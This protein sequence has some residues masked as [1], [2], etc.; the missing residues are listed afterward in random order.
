VTLPQ[1]TKDPR[2]SLAILEA[3]NARPPLG[4]RLGFKDG[5][6]PDI[7]L[8]QKAAR[9]VLLFLVICAVALADL[10]EAAF[11]RAAVILIADV[12][13]AALNGADF[14]NLHPQERSD[15]QPLKYT[16]ERSRRRNNID[17]KS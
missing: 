3:R 4:P 1:D 13:E 10:D 2:Q 12:N 5:D 7:V 16:Q 8:V 17:S 9:L 11:F 6:L 14:K 15:Q